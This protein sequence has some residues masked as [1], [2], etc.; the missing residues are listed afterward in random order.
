MFVLLPSFGSCRCSVFTGLFKQASL[1][2]F[3]AEKKAS[4]TSRH[5][6]AR[7]ARLS[8][9][10]CRAVPHIG[11]KLKILTETYFLQ[12]IL[13]FLQT[14]NMKNRIILAQGLWV[15]P[16]WSLQIDLWVSVDNVDVRIDPLVTP[17]FFKP[18]CASK[19]KDELWR[20]FSKFFA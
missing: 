6:S 13:A 9:H 12:L 5:F 4:S 18:L 2:S 19:A 10:H 20:H 17:L 11:L 1:A 14:L 7:L 8:R 16:A 3:K 15:A